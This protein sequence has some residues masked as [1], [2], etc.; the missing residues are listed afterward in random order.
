MSVQGMFDAG[1]M[2]DTHVYRCTAVT[3]SASEFFS[4]A[5]ERLTFDVPQG[6]SIRAS[7]RRTTSPTLIPP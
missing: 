1:P 4:C 5:Q 7:S 3:M 2:E 6:S